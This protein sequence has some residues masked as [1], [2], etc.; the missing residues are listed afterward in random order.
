LVWCLI[1]STNFKTQKPCCW[2]ND[3]ASYTSYTA[4]GLNDARLIVAYENTLQQVFLYLLEKRKLKKTLNSERRCMLFCCLHERATCVQAQ[5]NTMRRQ[6]DA[7][8][9]L[10]SSDQSALYYTLGPSFIYLYSIFLLLW[11]LLP[12][13]F[14]SPGGY[15][16]HSHIQMLQ[17]SYPAS[18][19]HLTENVEKRSIR[20]LR[21]CMPNCEFRN[22]HLSFEWRIFQYSAVISAQASV[23]VMTLCGNVLAS[24]LWKLTV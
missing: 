13:G 10:L 5:K 23:N 18:G 15:I 16:R 20:Y 1:W 8:T 14:N 9:Q 19:K 22:A 11:L 21:K 6:T 2:C 4:V 17:L 12:Q 7:A 24:T 3:I